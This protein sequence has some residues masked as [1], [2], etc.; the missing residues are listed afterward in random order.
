MCGCRCGSSNRS[1]SVCRRS[2]SLMIT[3]VYSRNSPRC[4]RRFRIRA[5][6]CAA[7]AA[8]RVL[9]LVR[10]VADQL[11]VDRGQVVDAFLAIGAR[12]PLVLEQL[13]EHEIGRGLEKADDRVHMQRFAAGPVEHGIEVRRVKAFLAD[14]GDRRCQ[15]VRIGKN[16]A[17]GRCASCRREMSSIASA[18][19]FANAIRSVLRSSTITTVGSAS[20]PA[21]RPGACEPLVV[22][23]SLG[24]PR[25]R[26][27]Q[28][29]QNH[30]RAC[31]ASTGQKRKITGTKGT[32]GR[33][34]FQTPPFPP[35]AA[36]RERTGMTALNR[37][38]IAD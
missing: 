32:A 37:S 29:L 30:L 23:Q 3:C 2:D 5:V 16:L 28:I 12:L 9:D 38:A 15:L 21:S 24:L 1:T 33:R 36:R 26:L 35:Q 25:S 6:S 4:A 17:H 8:E 14:R 27:D 13:D 18:D 7:N 11:L 10:E 20:S 19:G 34:P 22:R 31:R